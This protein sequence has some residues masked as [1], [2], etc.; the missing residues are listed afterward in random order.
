GRASRIVVKIGR[1]FR[2]RAPELSC[3]IR[4]EASRW[5]DRRRDPRPLADALAP[6]VV[7]ECLAHMPS[8]F[9]VGASDP[10]IG[11]VL[12]E[13]IP[14]ARSSLIA[15]AESA[16]AGQLDLLGYRRLSFGDPIDWHLDPV[17]ARRA[18]RVHSSLL[19]PL[20][21]DAVGDSK[22]IWEL[23]RHQWLIGLGQA[24]RLTLDDRYASHAVAALQAWQAENPPGIGINWT[25]SL[26]V[27][28]RLISWCWLLALCRG[29]AALSP[30]VQRTLVAGIAEHA[31]RVERYLSYYF[32]PNTH[33]TGEALGL[34][35]AGA[36]FPSLP[37]SARWRRLATEIL[38]RESG[39][40]ILPDGVYMEQATCYQ[41]YTAEIYL[42]FAALSA[43]N[44]IA[45]PDALGRRVQTLLDALLALRRPDRSL[46]AIG[47]AD[48]GWLLPLTP[49]SPGDADGVF[50]LAGTLFGRPEYG[51]AAAGLTPEVA[52]L[53][54][55]DGIAAWDRM[56]PRSPDWA[57]RL[58]PQGGYA[59]M[60]SGWGRDADQVMVD[61]GPLGDPA[62]VAHGHADLLSI[63]CSFGGAPYI[64]DPG[65]FQYVAGPWRDHYRTTAAH[66][67]IEVDGLGQAE[68]R[69]PFGWDG[70]PGA[71][72]V[73]WSS[74]PKLD[75]VVAEHDAYRRLPDPVRHRRAVLLSKGRCGVI[76]DDV[77]GASEHRLVLRFQFAPMSVSLDA[78]GWARAARGDGSGLLVHA[79]ATTALKAA[80]LEGETEPR[81]GWVSGAYGSHVPAPVLTLSATGVLPVRIVTLLYP[82]RSISADPPVVSPVH[83]DGS[84]RGLVFGDGFEVV[85]PQ[86]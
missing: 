81:Q 66:S 20:D 13:R 8:R 49:R 68:P 73:H 7:D 57:S 5:L 22:V 31:T 56:E 58:L 45:V 51:W 52:W 41:R 35:Y 55:R 54:G 48:G 47:D 34:F 84:L 64:V 1:L 82:A 18:P 27:S 33:L 19:D 62:S 4:H 69:G 36:T 15:A 37:A 21:P 25:S 75:V 9:F 80:V 16:L 44:G 86:P 70:R 11:S 12:D 2:M 60:R 10:L 72:I 38:T 30:A 40:Q 79:F 23:N 32:S 74:D 17:S 77:V 76:I 29:A 53:L 63:Q 6:G 39:R 71:R 3:R 85:W 83:V 26:E 28:I 67:T 61:G 65:T 59:V 78:S 50:G 14:E 46:P 42:H 24:Y 43:R